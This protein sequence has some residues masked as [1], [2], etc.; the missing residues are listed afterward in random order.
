MTEQL[1]E[2]HIYLTEHS[3]YE[4]IAVVGGALHP[5]LAPLLKVVIPVGYIMK[6][7]EN[8]SNE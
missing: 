2:D 8:V 4:Y 6:N 5:L 1:S 7:S 3:P